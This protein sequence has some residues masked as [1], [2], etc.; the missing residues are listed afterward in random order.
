MEAIRTASGKPLD[1]RA[2]RTRQAIK[3]SFVALADI[4]KPQ[5]LTVKEV[6]E[7]AGVNRA[8]FYAH[9]SNIDDLERALEADAAARVIEHAEA[10]LQHERD[11]GD[12]QAD[13]FSTLMACLLGDRECS[14]WILG[15]QALGAG[16]AALAEHLRNRCIQEWRSASDL[17]DEQAAMLFSYVFE[18][19]FGLLTHCYQHG[20]DPKHALS[21]VSALSRQ[22]RADM[23]TLL[24]PR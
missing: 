18:G 1:R 3:Q 14:R 13:R 12:H 2:R 19:S 24:V 5:D 9:F 7:H 20:V 11:A 15:T 23:G 6:M 21:A 16:K 10:E 17:T 4:R 22:T 8:T